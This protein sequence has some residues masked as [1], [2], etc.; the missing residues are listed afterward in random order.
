MVRVGCGRLGRARDGSEGLDEDRSKDGDEG[1]DYVVG[2]SVST[3]GE[4]E[5][6]VGIS[7]RGA[8]AFLGQRVYVLRRA[9]VG[10]TV[11]YSSW[12][13]GIS[14]IMGKD[15]A[16]TELSVSELGATEEKKAKFVVGRGIRQEG[17]V[18]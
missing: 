8:G 1:M 17:L 12:R 16:T 7:N 13:E 5:G 3:D 4:G 15:M 10:F 11:G 9:R 2:K 18:T 6:G 14:E